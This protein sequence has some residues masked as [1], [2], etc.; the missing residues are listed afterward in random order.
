MEQQ[1]HA[2][3]VE[4]AFQQITLELKG[5][6]KS[7]RRLDRTGFTHPTRHLGTARTT[8]TIEAR[9]PSKLPQGFRQTYGP[10]VISIRISGLPMPFGEAIIDGLKLSATKAIHVCNEMV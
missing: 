9:N 8:R 10:Y 1:M 6:I 3:K 5:V 4:D 2:L 7:F